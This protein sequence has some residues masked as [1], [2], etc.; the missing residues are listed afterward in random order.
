MLH[1]VPLKL[2]V[3]VCCC[4]VCRVVQI[5]IQRDNW[6]KKDCNHSSCRHVSVWILAMP[7]HQKYW[8]DALLSIMW[9]KKISKNYDVVFDSWWRSVC[10]SASWILPLRY[11]FCSW[12]AFHL[13]TV[14]INVVSLCKCHSYESIGIANG[15]QCHSCSDD[16]TGASYEKKSHHPSTSL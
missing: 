11:I 5:Q 4:T 16:T 12:H 10:I 1:S 7:L 2:I 13:H 9:T 14:V 15:G 6:I 8:F 3:L